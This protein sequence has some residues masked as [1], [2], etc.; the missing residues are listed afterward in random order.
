MRRGWRSKGQRGGG[1]AA[2]HLSQKGWEHRVQEGI[3]HSK[4]VGTIGQTGNPDL[5]GISL[6]TKTE[7]R[8]CCIGK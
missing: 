2:K 4:K 6:V 8:L 1:Y 5:T 3:V 7:A